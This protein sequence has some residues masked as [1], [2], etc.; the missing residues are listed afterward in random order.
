[1]LLGQDWDGNFFI[2]IDQKLRFPFQGSYSTTEGEGKGSDQSVGVA[3][4]KFSSKFS[5]TVEDKFSRVV[6]NP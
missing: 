6:S 5:L 1:M 4:I 2:I 3:Y